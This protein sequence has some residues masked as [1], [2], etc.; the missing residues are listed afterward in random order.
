MFE[1]L[2][3]MESPILCEQ[4]MGKYPV[5]SITL[6]DVEGK[7]YRTAYDALC[8]VVSAEAERFDYLLDSEKLISYDKAKLVRIIEGGMEKAAYLQ[9]GHEADG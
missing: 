6:K 2:E 3:I 1:G 7:D 8:M 4:Y 5:I 9:G